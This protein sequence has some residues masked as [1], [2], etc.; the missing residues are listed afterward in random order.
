VNFSDIDALQRELSKRGPY[1]ANRVVAL[2]SR[3]FTMA[4]KWRM[5]PD[6]PVKGIERND[7]DKRKRYLSPSE[8]VRL[9]VA[10]DQHSNQ[11]SANIIRL[12]LLT[13]ARSGETMQAKWSDVDLVTRVWTKPGATTKQRSVHVL[14]LSSAAVQLIQRIRQDVPKGVVWLFPAADGSHRRGVKDSWGAICK[15]ADIVGVRVH[16]L[17]HTY[18]SV[19]ASSGFSLPV[20]GALLGHTQPSTTHRYAHLFDDP[21][22]AATERASEIL[23]GAAS[24]EVVPL[25]SDRRRG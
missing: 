11:Q 19:L 3:M 14:P 15:A 20:I 7:E 22:R 4:V 1:R 18:A 17:R 23:T 25:S 21:L 12:L 24:A 8:L 16:D 2:V 5:R 9:A 10:L 13:G 6:N